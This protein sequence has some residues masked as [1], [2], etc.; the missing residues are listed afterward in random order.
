MCDSHGS[1]DQTST[2]SLGSD[3]NA[4]EHQKPMKVC[5][6]KLVDC[7]NSKETREETT[8]EKEKVQSDDNSN[9][10]NDDHCDDDDFIP[11]GMSMFP[12]LT[13]YSVYLIK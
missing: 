4:G 10:D 8:A 3:C 1:A 13:F 7:K 2:E 11:S 5:S 9:N 12:R 6:I